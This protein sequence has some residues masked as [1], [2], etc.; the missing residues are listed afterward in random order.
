MDVSSFVWKEELRSV[1]VN[2]LVNVL[3][4]TGVSAF[5]SEP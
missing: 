3:S 4:C 1:Y 2:E 5:P